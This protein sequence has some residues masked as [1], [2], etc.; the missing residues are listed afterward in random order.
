MPARSIPCLFTQ[1]AFGVLA[2]LSSAILVVNLIG[3]MLAGQVREIGVMKTIGAGS[4]QIAGMY[5]GLALVLGLVACVV[6]IPAAALIGVQYARFTADTLNFDIGGFT[7]P[8]PIFL[9]QLAVGALLPVA[10]A[11][12]PVGRGC[13]IS[14]GV[15]LRD[16]G[17]EAAHAASGPAV[18]GARLRRLPR[19]LLLSLRNAFRRRQRMALTL[20]T[21]ATGGAVFIGA[22]DLRTAIRSSVDRLFD[23]QRYDVGLRFETPW[24]P[25][26]SKLRSQPCPAWPVSRLGVRPGSPSRPRTGTMGNTFALGAPP[27]ARNCS[28]PRCALAACR[29]PVKTGRS[30]STAVYRTTN[31][32]WPSVAP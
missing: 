4:G 28:S 20:M 30:S 10:A 13:R 14:V 12:I 5:L 27:R 22:L 26:S 18:F 29:S 17:I 25:S 3:A 7:I 31:R 19:P 8:P 1:G 21:L 9:L 24:P 2:L 11:A 16:F 32:A 6:A 23:S 15:A